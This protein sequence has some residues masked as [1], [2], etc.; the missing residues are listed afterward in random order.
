MDRSLALESVTDDSCF[1]AFRDSCVG[2]REC[3]I[4]EHYLPPLPP[5]LDNLSHS[6]QHQQLGLC[7]RPA[8]KPVWLSSH[9]Y[10]LPK[11]EANAGGEGCTCRS[12]TSHRRKPRREDV[13]QLWP[14]GW[15]ARARLSWEAQFGL[16]RLARPTRYGW[17]ILA[18][19]QA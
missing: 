18:M 14:R 12:R 2:Q 19:P 1:P 3:L 10:T 9:C 16:S 13:G 8:L 15:L 17:P 6:A 11:F 4:D 5:P 7:P